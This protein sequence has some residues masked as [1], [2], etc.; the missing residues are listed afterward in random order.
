MKLVGLLAII[1]ASTLCGA[2]NQTTETIVLDCKGASCYTLLGVACV[3]AAFLIFMMPVCV[4]CLCLAA[5]GIKILSQNSQRLF[6]ATAN[7]LGNVERNV[8][9]R[10]Q[11]EIQGMY[12]GYSTY[13]HRDIRVEVVTSV[14]SIMCSFTTSSFDLA[15]T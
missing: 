8:Q 6:P 13:M 11:A 4:A 1:L 5:K 3:V 10:Q 7:G 9:E 2:E 14:T 12:V 15:R